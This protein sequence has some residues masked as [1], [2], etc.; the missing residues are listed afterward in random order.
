MAAV[1]ADRGAEG[2]DLVAGV[3]DDPHP[4]GWVGCVAGPCV[5]GGDVAE[6]CASFDVIGVDGDTTLLVEGVEDLTGVLAGAHRHGEG[7]ILR[8]VNGRGLQGEVRVLGYGLRGVVQDP[9]AAHGGKLV[10]VA[11]ERDPGAGLIGDAQQGAGGV[12][13]QQ[14]P[15]SSTSSGSPANSRASAGGRGSGRA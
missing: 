9:A 1:V 2:G 4:I 12:L 7:G 11:E 3:G 15:A 5:L 6:C 14:V 8:M 10:P 13:V